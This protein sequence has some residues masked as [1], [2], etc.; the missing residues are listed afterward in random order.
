MATIKTFSEFS[1]SYT[2]N[3]MLLQL[4]NDLLQLEPGQECHGALKIHCTRPEHVEK[5]FIQFIGVAKTEWKLG[6]TYLVGNSAIV[7]KVPYT[8]ERHYSGDEV[9]L[10]SKTLTSG[11]NILP[12]NMTVPVEVP[13]SFENNLGCIRYWIKASVQRGSGNSTIA[14]PIEISTNPVVKCSDFLTKPIRKESRRDLGKLF[15]KNGH[16]RAAIGVQKAT[17][18]VG[19]SMEVNVEVD[20]ESE[21]KITDIQFQLVQL[22]HFSAQRDCTRPSL[23]RN[24]KEVEFKQ[25]EFVVKEWCDVV[26]IEKHERAT[27]QDVLRVPEVIPSFNNCQIVQV[28]YVLRTKIVTKTNKTLLCCDIPVQ[29]R[30]VSSE[31]SANTSPR[32]SLS[33]EIN[34]YQHPVN[35]PQPILTF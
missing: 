2:V 21:K 22:S 7:D 27:Y 3:T 28:N 25:D 14:I 18:S 1:M 17:F 5:I 23:K 31:Y 30:G 4:E 6:E 35:A 12:F 15:F 16:V 13:P 10:P 32:S 26:K 33:V 9:V 24:H 11:M 8:S 34:A 19:E 29:I 20:N